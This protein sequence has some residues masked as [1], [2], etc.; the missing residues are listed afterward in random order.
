MDQAENEHVAA[1]DQQESKNQPEHSSFPGFIIDLIVLPRSNSI[2]ESGTTYKLNFKATTYLPALNLSSKV[3]E[4]R[5]K[6]GTIGAAEFKKA[7]M[8]TLKGMQPAPVI[9]VN[10]SG[11]KPATHDLEVILL[12]IISLFLPSRP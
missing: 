7:I 11:A 8:H 3:Q 6:C 9:N 5:K 10:Y 12:K 2:I 1:A 4:Q